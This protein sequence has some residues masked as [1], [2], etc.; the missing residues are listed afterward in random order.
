MNARD[1]DG[2]LRAGQAQ[3]SLAEL[4]TW[5]DAVRK[6][7]NE[8]IALV[9]ANDVDLF[10]LPLRS[11]GCLPR[12]FRGPA[13]LLSTSHYGLPVPKSEIWKPEIPDPK[14]QIDG[15]GDGAAHR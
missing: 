14:S 7:T 6:Q 15:Y 12:E 8:I 4:M 2:A 9:R 10:D 13:G 5:G 11:D 3:L 1:D